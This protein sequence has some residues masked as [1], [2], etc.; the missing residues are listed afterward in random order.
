MRSVPTH[1][2]H[3]RAFDDASFAT[4]HDHTSQYKFIVL[5]CDIQENTCVLHYAG[6]KSLGIPRY[7]LV[8][9]TY[10]L[11]AAYDFKNCAK[12]DLKYILDRT[13]PLAIHADSKILF[14]FIT[15]FSQAE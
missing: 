5:L 14:H 3:I 7:V 13:A 8:A 1:A 6:Y 11:A 9:V 10:P 15:K 12:R 4:N 2:D